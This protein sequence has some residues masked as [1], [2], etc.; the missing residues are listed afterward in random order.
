MLELE[1]S[2]DGNVKNKSYH[3]HIGHI[4]TMV[5][6]RIEIVKIDMLNI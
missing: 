1:K 3:F 5:R 2:G 4:I 6:V